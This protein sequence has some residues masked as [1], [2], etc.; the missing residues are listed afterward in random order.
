MKI[1]DQTLAGVLILLGI[2]HNFIAAPLSFDHFSTDFLWFVTGGLALWYAG[3]INLLR[4]RGNLCGRLADWLCLLTNLS[5][6]AFAVTF[7]TV[8]GTWALPTTWLLVGPVIGL[9]VFSIRPLLA[10]DGKKIS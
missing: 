1:L 3:F 6:L 2:I 4:A 9:T 10:K 5:F 8:S 7:P